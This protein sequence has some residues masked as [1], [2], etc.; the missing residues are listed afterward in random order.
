M[1]TTNLLTIE[2]LKGI[3]Y[4]KNGKGGQP[5]ELT[6]EIERCTTPQEVIAYAR[7]RN[8]AIV[9]LKFTD[10]LGRWHHFSMPLYHFTENVF[11]EGIGFDGSSI[12]AFQEIL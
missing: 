4:S 10:L 2:E 6:P 9:D 7:S 8:I 3:A 11:N 12:R 5:H 1:A